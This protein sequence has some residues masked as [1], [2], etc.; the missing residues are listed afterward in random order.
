MEALETKNN[1]TKI[2]AEERE[3][4]AQPQKAGEYKRE[5]DAFRAAGRLFKD[6]LDALDKSS[7]D[8]KDKSTFGKRTKTAHEWFDGLSK[9][10]KRE[11]EKV[12]VKWNQE[13]APKQQ[14][15]V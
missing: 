11:A 7:R 2:S 1:C 8:Q 4:A 6:E 5:W 3:A 10:K 13:G 15:V 14:Q 12:A 9:E